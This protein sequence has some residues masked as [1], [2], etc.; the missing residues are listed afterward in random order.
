MLEYVVKQK[1]ADLVAMVTPNKLDSKERPRSKV[2][3]ITE[4]GG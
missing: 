4:G 3:E 2:L 1:R